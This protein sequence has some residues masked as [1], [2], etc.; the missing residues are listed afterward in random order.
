MQI[1]SIDTQAIGGSVAVRLFT[2]DNGEREQIVEFLLTPM[3]SMSF[4]KSIMSKASEAL[5]QMTLNGNG[6]NGFDHTE[7]RGRHSK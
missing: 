2:E 4:A 7:K 3:D 1:S 6:H 5:E